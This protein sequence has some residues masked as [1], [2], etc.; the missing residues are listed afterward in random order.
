M[1]P[2]DPIFPSAPPAFPPPSMPAPAPPVGPGR[3]PGLRR[4][5][6]GLLALQLPFAALALVVAGPDDAGSDLALA[7]D[8]TEAVDSLRFE[9]VM[10]LTADGEH[11]EVPMLRG[12]EV[13]DRGHVVMASLDE[14]LGGA[15][16]GGDVGMEL[17]TDGTVVYVRA[18]MFA[19]LDDLGGAVPPAIEPLV[20]LG[21]RWGVIDVASTDASPEVIAAA[22]GTGGFDLA[23]GLDLLRGA[24]DDLE[25]SG[26]G[27]V[28]G[29]EVTEFEGTITFEDL[30][31]AQGGDLSMLEGMFPADLG[32]LDLG[33]MLDAMASIDL[34]FEVAVDDEGLVRRVAFGF[35]ES[36]IEAVL[37]EL[38]V[39]T[40][41]AGPDLEMHM[42]IELFGLGDPSI[43]V[44]LPQIDDP[45]DL[46]PWALELAE[47]F[48][49]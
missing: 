30:F 45:V 14:L 1:E 21:D 43:T 17:F 5:T 15:P 41:G 33:E 23:T 12:E 20:E 40:P 11:L 25:E 32:G 36:F 39:P 28:R 18:P 48:G 35:D 6:A 49:D 16:A 29:V 46:T 2:F 47:T 37:D 38:D 34:D 7:A 31:D 8:R 26:V 24:A 19:A 27:Q 3:R 13:G 9:V 44:D 42:A 10:E 22:T 4:A